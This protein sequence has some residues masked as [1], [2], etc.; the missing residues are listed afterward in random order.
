MPLSLVTH[1][2]SEW[3]ETGDR[4]FDP[5]SFWVVDRR[6]SSAGRL[7]RAS[8]SCGFDDLPQ[9]DDSRSQ[10]ALYRSGRS[11]H[12]SCSVQKRSRGQSDQ[13]APML[14]SHDGRASE[15]CC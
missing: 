3:W 10:T 2:R 8:A 7:H 6:S 14:Y 4:L 9:R 5:A 12:P 15:S 11:D 13:I 1:V